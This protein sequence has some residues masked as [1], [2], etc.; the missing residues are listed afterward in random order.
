L[1]ENSAT[2]VW[3]GDQDASHSI[4]PAN[5]TV[6]RYLVHQALSYVGTEYHKTVGCLFNPTISQDV[7]DYFAQ[8][9]NTKLT[10]LND[11]YLKDKEFVVGRKLSVAD[12]YLYICL[13]RSGYLN[14]D[15]TNYPVVNDYFKRIGAIQAL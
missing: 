7:R 13:S 11:N 2:L 9:T 4:I 3:I 14:I 10:F 1:N 15:L 12:V 5:G 6:D 8:A